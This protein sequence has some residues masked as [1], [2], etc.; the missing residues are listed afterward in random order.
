MKID[1]LEEL[2]SE[3]LAAVLSEKDQS[4]FENARAQ[5]IMTD[6]GSDYEGFSE[7]FLFNYLDLESGLTF[8]ERFA[9]KRS[10]VEILKKSFRSIFEVRYEHEETYLKDIFTKE[11]FKVKGIPLNSDELVS[12][13]LVPIEDTY[14][15]LG[16]IFRVDAGYRTLIE[17]QVLEQFNDYIRHYGSTSMRQF[18]NAQNQL[19]FKMMHVIQ[20]TGETLDEESYLLHQAQYAY[21]RTREE[22][23]NILEQNGNG[24]TIE[25]VEASIY[26]MFVG[27]SLFAELE[28]ND[29]V[30]YV[31]CN[32]EKH[33]DD[34]V[35]L[36]NPLLDEDFVFLSK[37]VVTLDELL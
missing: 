25:Y 24:F 10:E 9:A 12:L 20:I 6:D 1:A 29:P 18:L 13:R 22:I 5:F 15:P 35:N 8:V 23:V 27:E 36:F 7:W 33:L 21:K 30:L 19:V 3:M 28:F 11:D 32:N 14:E 2:F 17:K 26:N 31:L 34:I 16:D 4:A 37:D